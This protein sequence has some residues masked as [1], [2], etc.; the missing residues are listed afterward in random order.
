MSVRAPG[1]R[2]SLPMQLTVT[3][4]LLGSLLWAG[5]RL[6]YRPQLDRQPGSFVHYES[7]VADGFAP[8]VQT[9][10]TDQ[11]Y[12][13]IESAGLSLTSL[14]PLDGN[15]REPTSGP[16]KFVFR[17]PV[18]PTAANGKC[19]PVG[20]AGAFLNGVP[21]YS[22][23]S[24]VSFRDQNLW[25]LDAVAALSKNARAAS[26]VVA[27]LFSNSGRHSPI[28][29]FALDGYPIYGP[30]GR[31]PDGH[32]Q[33]LRSSYRL[34][35]IT[36]RTVLPD[37]T[38]LTPARGPPVDS[39]YPLGTFRRITSMFPRAGDLDEHNSRCSLTPEYPEGT[40]AYFLSAYPY[41]VGPTYFRVCGTGAV[42]RAGRASCSFGLKPPD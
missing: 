5:D 3:L 19:A 6:L 40:Y 25:H 11:Q 1:R 2:Y 32:V 10:R 38:E 28:I 20:V 34:R 13:Y 16:R 42:I 22:P 31:D 26:P 17:F 4:F 27:S 36:R 14:G 33:R 23:I 35:S 39:E 37:G 30:Y 8:E 7:S 24:V 21:I 9:V 41:L 18:A 29:G 15:D 12:V